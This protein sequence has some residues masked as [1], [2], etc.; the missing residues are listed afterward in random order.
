M[1]H[2]RRHRD[3]HRYAHTQ[4]AGSVMMHECCY[5]MQVCDTTT[6]HT[7]ATRLTPGSTVIIVL[8]TAGHG[9]IVDGLRAAFTQEQQCQ[10]NDIASFVRP[11]ALQL[12]CHLS[13]LSLL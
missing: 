5:V 10:V 3:N 12:N 2:R 11:C 9:G 6:M 7:A 8:V 4:H 13:P 1:I